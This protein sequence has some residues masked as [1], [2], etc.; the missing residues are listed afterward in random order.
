MEIEGRKQS[1]AE[2]TATALKLVAE[3]A[4]LWTEK[5]GHKITRK[6]SAATR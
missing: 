5:I 3:G 4:D 2:V 6:G 1:A